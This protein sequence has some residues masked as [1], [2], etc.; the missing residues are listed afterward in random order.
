R[1]RV[2]RARTFLRLTARDDLGA[3][4]PTALDE[5]VHPRAVRVGDQRPHLR[6]GIERIADLQPAG[7]VDELGDELVV[8]RL[9]DEHARTRLATLTGGVV[10]RPDRAR[11]RVR[12]VRVG[13]DEVRAL[14]AE[15][16]R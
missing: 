12:E 8:E 13:E 16:E 5:V 10:D 14:A 4:L 6:L 11:D 3:L 15:L 1:R 7:L 9:L 2:E